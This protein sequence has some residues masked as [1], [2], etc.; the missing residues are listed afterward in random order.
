MKMAVESEFPGWYKFEVV[1][2]LRPGFLK[3][4]SVAPPP[5]K[6]FIV[7]FDLPI[8]EVPLHSVPPSLRVPNSVIWCLV[9]PDFSISRVAADVRKLSDIFRGSVCPTK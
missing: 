7:L 2:F 9:E 5:P 4:M 6:G 8:D 3:V 1:G